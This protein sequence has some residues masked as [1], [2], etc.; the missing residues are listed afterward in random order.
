[1]KRFMLIL[2][3]GMFTLTCEK[4][5]PEPVSTPAPTPSAPSATEASPKAPTVSLKAET[6]GT[7]KNLHVFG[8]THLAGQPGEADLAL[9]KERGIKAVVTLRED[10]EN[11]GFDEAQTAEKIGLPFHRVA[12]RAPDTLT[13]DV[14]EQV[15]ALIKKHDGAVLLHCGSANRVGAVWAAKR[16]LD[17]GLTW[18]AALAEAK[19]VG[20]SNAGYE[21]KA[22]AYVEAHQK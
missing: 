21:A 9:L 20:L 5:A 1:M 17:D 2:I 13:D 22:K 6:C 16:V 12:F 14:F 11:A 15:R 8:A 10:S 4:P 19:E 18:D 3:V 7:V